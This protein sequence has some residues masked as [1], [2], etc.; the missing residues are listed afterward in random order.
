MVAQYTQMLMQQ[1]Q[2]GPAVAGQKPAGT[3]PPHANGTH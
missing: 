1:Q 2:R 3:A